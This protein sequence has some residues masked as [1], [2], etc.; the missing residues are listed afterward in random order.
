[1]EEQPPARERWFLRWLVPSSMATIHT[2]RMSGG[3]ARSGT[4]DGHLPDHA[5]NSATAIG[6]SLNEQKSRMDEAMLIK[7]IAISRSKSAKTVCWPNAYKTADLTVRL[8]GTF[9]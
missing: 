8:P 6:A 5:K 1:M 2:T 9:F 7:M 3:T 4:I